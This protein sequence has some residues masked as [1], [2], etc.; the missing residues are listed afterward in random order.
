MPRM[1]LGFG[2]RL[3]WKQ[4]SDVIR[5]V[6]SLKSPA[7]SLSAGCT[8]KDMSGPWGA[9]AMSWRWCDEIGQGGGWGVTAV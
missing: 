9:R 2:P 6:R 8:I 3:G 1:E 5:L 4:I 7:T